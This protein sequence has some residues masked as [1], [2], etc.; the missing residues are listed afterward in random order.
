[1]SDTL[2]KRLIS[3]ANSLTGPDRTAERVARALYAVLREYAEADGQ[4]PDIEVSIWSPAEIAQRNAPHGYAWVV[5]WEAGPYEW[6]VPVSMGIDLV[7][8]D[9]VEPYWSFDLCIYEKR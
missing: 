6:A 1:M 2:T 5:N 9:P 4:N 7:N 8:G 3:A